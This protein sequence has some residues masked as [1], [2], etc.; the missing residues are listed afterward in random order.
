MVDE[1]QAAELEIADGIGYLPITFTELLDCKKQELVM[2]KDGKAARVDQS[3]HGKDYW[4]ADYDQTERTWSLTYN[5]PLDTPGD[6]RRKVR[7]ILRQL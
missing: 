6:E 3:V 7:L 1:D 4:Q 2:V 5:V